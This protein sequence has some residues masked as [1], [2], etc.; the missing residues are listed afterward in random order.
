MISKVR[1]RLA[2][3]DLTM[4]KILG[5]DGKDDIQHESVGDWTEEGHQ[6]PLFEDP[7]EVEV[8]EGSRKST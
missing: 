6:E 3:R 7:A 8:I 5:D 4:N 1:Q 2:T